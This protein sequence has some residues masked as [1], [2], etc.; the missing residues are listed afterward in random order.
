MED[1]VGKEEI[2]KSPLRWNALE[3]AFVLGVDLD[4]EAN[5][6][7]EKEWEIRGHKRK[8]GWEAQSSWGSPPQSGSLFHQ[9][10]TRKGNFIFV[11]R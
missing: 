8:S 10:T 5:W 3:L 2:G 1:G 9:A 4:P 6:M 11:V 7:A